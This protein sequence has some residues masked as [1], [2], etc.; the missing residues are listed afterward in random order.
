MVPNS[1]YASAPNMDTKPQA[2]Q[3]IR[4]IAT[5]PVL[6]YI[7]SNNEVFARQKVFFL[8]LLIRHDILVVDINILFVNFRFPIFCFGPVLDDLLF[9]LV[10]DISVFFTDFR[11]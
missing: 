11:I 1:A 9:R 2:T 5:E 4:D 6:M 7:C 8:S 3:T 10:I